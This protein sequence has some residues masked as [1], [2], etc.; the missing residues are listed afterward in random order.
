MNALTWVLLAIC[1]AELASSWLFRR[2]M[3]KQHEMMVRLYSEIATNRRNDA[4]SW[5]K[6]SFDFS[7]TEKERRD[8]YYHAAGAF[9]NAHA[10]EEVAADIEHVLINRQ[11]IGS[12]RMY[13]A[14]E[15]AKS[16]SP[17]QAH[18]IVFSSKGGDA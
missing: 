11:P 12:R 14:D 1:L 9:G 18:A 8:A 10:F 4:E 3:K 2:R 13:Q 16:E 6:K 17:K 7:L 5:S 15:D